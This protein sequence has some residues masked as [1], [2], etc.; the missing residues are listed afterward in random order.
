MFDLLEGLSPDEKQ[1]ARGLYDGASQK[2][3]AARLAI[4]QQG[5]SKRV[6]R[7]REKLRTSLYS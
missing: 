7:L 5:V 6:G 1:L 3:L 4:S 2:E